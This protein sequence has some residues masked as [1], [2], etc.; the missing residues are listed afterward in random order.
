MEIRSLFDN[1]VPRDKMVEFY[2]SLDLFICS[3]RSEHIPM[4]ILE[5]A[6]SGIP[7]ITTKVGIVPE[8][9]KSHRNGIIVKRSAIREAEQYMIDHPDERRAMG[10]NVRQSILERWRWTDCAKVW[11]QIFMSLME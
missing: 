11:E 7:I 6:S 9:I 8:L 3:S 1:Y 5:A 4:P 10:A 2:Q